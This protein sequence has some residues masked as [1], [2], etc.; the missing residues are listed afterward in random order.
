MAVF[1]Q[2]RQKTDVNAGAAA[3]IMPLANP[4]ITRFAVSDLCDGEFCGLLL[5]LN[6]PAAAEVQ[7]KLGAFQALQGHKAYFYPPSSLHC[8]V[9]TLRAF[10][11]G[12]LETGEGGPRLAEAARWAAV[13]DAAAAMPE[14]PKGTITLRMNAPSFEGAAGI[15]RYDEVSPG[16]A[17]D[18]MRACLRQ[19]IAAAGGVAAEG[20]A[21][22]SSARALSGASASEP[23]PHLPN[24]IHSTVLRWAA[25][26][27]EEEV[28][29]ARAEFE[30]VGASWEPLEF[31]VDAGTVRGVFEDRPFMHVPHTAAQVFWRAPGAAKCPCLVCECGSDCKCV[32]GSPGCDACGAFQIKAK[33]AAADGAKK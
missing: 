24:I 26:P 3:C 18:A 1:S 13:L 2:T 27:S 25:E 11:G 32:P 7:A 31:T 28:Q 12:P 30:R 22:R 15:L 21:D 20:S 9:A 6:W 4:I 29:A 17:I 33:Q 23:A 16:G 19:A 5:V 8:T 14:W 10:T